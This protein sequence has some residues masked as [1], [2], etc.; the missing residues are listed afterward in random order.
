MENEIIVYQLQNGKG[1]KTKLLEELYEKNKGFI[2]KTAARWTRYAEKA[3]LMQE[4]YIALTQ[5]AA[6]YNESIGRPFI[7]YAAEWIEG[8]LSRYALKQYGTSLVMAERIAKYK[9]IAGRYE[10]E[11]GKPP[12]REQIAF[13]MV[14]KPG[15]VESIEKAITAAEKTSLEKP[16]TEDGQTLAEVIPGEDTTAEVLERII[17][18]QTA[19]KIW[20]EV[21]RLEE[22]EKQIIKARYREGQTRQQTADKYGMTE[23]KARHI[24]IRALKRLERK[25]AI[26]E[27]WEETALSM[28]YRSGYRDFINTGMSSTERAAFYMIEK[29][30][31][32]RAAAKVSY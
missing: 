13:I 5:A 7:S 26:R 19:G 18:E 6:A 21:D 30:G 32:K 23:A 14:C 16:I 12:T 11:H 28:S 25:R 4:G 10:Q 31:G 1:N 22:E 9:R 2:A 20:G 3:D 29:K 8:N 15:E 24:E 17:R 27:E